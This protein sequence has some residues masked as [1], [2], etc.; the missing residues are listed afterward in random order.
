MTRSGYWACT[1]F[2]VLALAGSVATARSRG[3]DESDAAEEAKKCAR[4]VQQGQLNLKDTISM[5]EKHLKATAVN[6][7]V[8]IKSAVE[9]PRKPDGPDRETGGTVDPTAQP[10]GDRLIYEITCVAGDKVSTTRIDGFLKMVVDVT[11]RTTPRT[12]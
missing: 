12:K 3:A 9:K 7:S 4:L 6:A 11:T 1:G 5:A 10:A 8:K 2:L